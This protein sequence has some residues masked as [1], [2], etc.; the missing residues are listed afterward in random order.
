VQEFRKSNHDSRVFKCKYCRKTR[1]FRRTNEI[2]LSV[3]V[4]KVC[5]NP[6]TAS[7]ECRNRKFFKVQVS[8]K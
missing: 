4:F 2:G 5:F 1:Q 7:K 6:T 3:K 8:E